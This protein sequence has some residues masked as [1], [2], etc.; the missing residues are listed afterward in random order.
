[1]VEWF[2]KA[3]QVGNVDANRYQLSKLLS[4]SLLAVPVS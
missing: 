2:K 3:R 1:M 4:V